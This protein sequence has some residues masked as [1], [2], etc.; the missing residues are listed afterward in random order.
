MDDQEENSM[1]LYNAFIALRL[2]ESHAQYTEKSL[3]SL[4]DIHFTRDELDHAQRT[5]TATFRRFFYEAPKEKVSHLQTAYTAFLTQCEAALQNK[6]N[7]DLLP[8]IIHCLKENDHI[9]QLLQ[10][11]RFSPESPDDALATAPLARCF[12]D[13]PRAFVS[14]LGWLIAH[15]VSPE[16]LLATH[17]IQDYFRY[18]LLEL[19]NPD[20]PIQF[21][22]EQLTA[23]PDTQALGVALNTTCCPEKGLSSYALDGSIHVSGDLT[24]TNQEASEPDF[25]TTLTEEHVTALTHT[26]G[27]YFL[28]YALHNHTHTNGLLEHFLNQKNHA[29][30]YLPVLFPHLKTHTILKSR[31]AACLSDETLDR[32]IDTHMSGLLVL[33]PYAPYLRQR[34]GQKELRTYLNTLEENAPSTLDLVSDLSQLLILFRHQ[35]TN[36]AILIF[37][38]LLQDIL[39]SPGYLLEDED[40]LTKL[41]QFR[42]AKNIL[43]EQLIQLDEAFNATLQDNLNPFDYIAIEDAWWSTRSKINSIQTIDNLPSLFPIDKHALHSLVA[44]QLFK[45]NKEAFDLDTFILELRIEPVFHPHQVTPYERLLINVLVTIDDDRIRSDITRRLDEHISDTKNWR[46]SGYVNQSLTKLACKNGNLGLIQWLKAE[47]ISTSKSPDTLSLVAA[48]SRHWHLVHYFHQTK[49]LKQ[50]TVDELLHLAVTQEV[51]S[52]IPGLWQIGKPTPRLRSVEHAFKQGV[53]QGDFKSIQA[54]LNCPTPPC[55]AVVTKGFKQA[56]HTQQF[57]LATQ[58]AEEVPNHTL[59]TAINQMLPEVVR[60]NKLGLLRCMG[61]FRTNPI[62]QNNL[63]DALIRAV[64]AGSLGAVRILFEFEH[65]TPRREVKKQALKQAN[66]KKYVHIA[67]FLSNSERSTTPTQQRISQ[68]TLPMSRSSSCQSFS[69]LP[70]LSFFNTA[71]ERQKPTNHTHLDKSILD[72]PKLERQ[73]SF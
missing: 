9:N 19:G 13:R 30:T 31:L 26:F 24:G 70:K 14:F 37:K 1:L 42:P 10:V 2:H 73:H 63:D 60:S 15:D 48:K 23:H 6:A 47:N 22:S 62:N 34:I 20:N 17:I 46:E 72:K 50:I 8:I 54:L 65:L 18:H 51:S 36:G 27:P 7:A 64:R 40:L 33:L 67:D 39:N 69:P 59:Q 11:L 61:T 41:R 43:S 56:I 58:L 57:T 12:I 5:K 71:S 32:L 3:E 25:Y 68:N 35:H 49:R 16:D 44:H 38:R 53:L 4:S 28:L 29:E 45:Q 52:A 66:K 55:S 21:L